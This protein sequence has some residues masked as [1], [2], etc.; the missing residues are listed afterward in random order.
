MLASMKRTKHL[1]KI[2]PA[3]LEEDEFNFV[4]EQRAGA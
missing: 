2:D 4:H 3:L 1:Y